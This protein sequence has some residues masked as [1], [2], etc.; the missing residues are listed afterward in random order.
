MNSDL[1][2]PPPGK[3]AWSGFYHESNR[4]HV[5]EIPGRESRWVGQV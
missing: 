5:S 3:V 2:H 1:Q 4:F